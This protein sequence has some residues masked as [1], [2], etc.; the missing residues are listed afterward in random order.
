M[1]ALDAMDLD[2][3]LKRLHLPTVRRLYAELEE[4]VEEEQ[5][6]YRDYLALLMA[7]EM[8][9]SMPSR[10]ACDDSIV[11]F[12]NAPA[13]ARASRTWSR[14]VLRMSTVPDRLPL[15]RLALPP[16][17]K[18]LSRPADPPRAVA[19]MFGDRKSVV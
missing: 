7:E 1:N 2:A 18:S 10:T 19:L 3:M 15:V 8:F 9:S 12:S 13:W 17:A 16:L 11:Y 14:V 5:T 6:S 4:R